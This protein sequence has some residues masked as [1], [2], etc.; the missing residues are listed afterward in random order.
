MRHLS[1][2]GLGVIF[3]R[4]VTARFQIFV[5]KL[6]CNCARWTLEWVDRL[7]QAATVALAMILR[8][9]LKSRGKYEK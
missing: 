6:S 5:R 2:V 4:K 7:R 3:S 8:Y 9:E 1:D